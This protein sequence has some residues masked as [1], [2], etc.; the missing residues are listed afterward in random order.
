MAGPQRSILSAKA[1]RLAQELAH[2]TGLPMNRIVEQALAHYDNELRAVQPIDAVWDLAAEGRK[3]I[4][5]GTTS[6][7]D[8]FYDG[9][10][11]PR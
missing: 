6:A 7:H 11:L 2:S 3:G 9:N 5:A 1:K 10:G 4:M 8:D